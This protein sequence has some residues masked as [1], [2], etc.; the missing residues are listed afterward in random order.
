MLLPLASFLSCLALLMACPTLLS[1]V[2][3]GGIAVNTTAKDRVGGINTSSAHGPADYQ[4]KAK[5]D[6]ENE[7]K[8][9]ATVDKSVGPLAVVLTAIPIRLAALT[10]DSDLVT[11]AWFF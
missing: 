10:A 5:L 8:P 7:V 4:A 9:P 3:G 1:T 6:R 2:A 11:V